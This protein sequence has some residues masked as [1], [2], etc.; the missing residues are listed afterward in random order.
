M[1]RFSVSAGDHELMS[2]QKCAGEHPG[3]LPI[4]VNLRFCRT[5][6]FMFLKLL[7]FLLWD[8]W[9]NSYLRSMGTSVVISNRLDG[10]GISPLGTC[11]PEVEVRV[12]D[13]SGHATGRKS[14]GID[15]SWG[16]SFQY[17][18]VS[19]NITVSVFYS[20]PIHGDLSPVEIGRNFEVFRGSE[21][22]NVP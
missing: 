3:E 6:S 16:I 14:C 4:V 22:H 7:P 18:K 19:F 11:K 17:L 8:E 21:S 9:R 1:R 12:L 5:V 15:F 20:R 10:E 2:V 13:P